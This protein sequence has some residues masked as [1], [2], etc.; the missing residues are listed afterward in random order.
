M[1]G[2]REHD[3]KLSGSIY[4]WNFLTVGKTASI[5]RRTLLH[6]VRWFLQAQVCETS[7]SGHHLQTPNC[8]RLRA[9]CGD[10]KVH[11]SGCMTSLSGN[12]SSF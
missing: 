5:S 4:A 8:T 11:C 1:L 10:G 9:L 12:S 2:C 3:N 6:G 7:V